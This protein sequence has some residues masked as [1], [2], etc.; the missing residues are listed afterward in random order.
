MQPSST[1]I[2]EMCSRGIAGVIA[3]WYGEASYENTVM[4][5][6][7]PEIQKYNAGQLAFQGGKVPAQSFLLAIME[8]QGAGNLKGCD[9]KGT[10]TSGLV[11]DLNYIKSHYEAQSF[12]VR[13]ASGTPVVWMFDVSGQHPTIDW[14]SVRSQA[15]GHLFIQE[16]SG[17]FSAAAAVADGGFAWIQINSNPDDWGSTYL[18]DFYAAASGSSRYATG[19]AWKGF[20]DSAASWGSHR[21]I[22]QHCG[23]SWLNTLGATSQT[24]R[25]LEAYPLVT[26]NDYEEGTALEPGI[27]NCLSDVALSGA[28]SQISWAPQFAAD[29][30]TTII[31]HYTVWA[32]TATDQMIN[33]SGPLPVSQSFYDLA[34]GTGLTAGTTYTI[35]V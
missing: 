10:C 3:D 6:W 17:G 28:G 25:A 12:Y 33:V 7:I 31:D 22:N 4:L 34:Q 18:R 27:D 2:Q 23:L 9:A 5:N 24:T 20:N 19:G 11:T 32:R 8:D 21:A 15:P 29:G 16:N 14:S 35:Y 13:S 26:W 30:N 1:P